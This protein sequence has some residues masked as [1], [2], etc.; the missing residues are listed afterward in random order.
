[1]GYELAIYILTLTTLY[2]RYVDRR[3]KND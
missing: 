2:H 3:H 1:V